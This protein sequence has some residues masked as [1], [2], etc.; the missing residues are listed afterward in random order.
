MMRYASSPNGRVRESHRCN[1]GYHADY[2]NGTPLAIWH[3]NRIF[4]KCKKNEGFL[5]NPNDL[6]E[7]LIFHESGVN[8]PSKETKVKLLSRNMG[9]F[10]RSGKDN[11]ITDSTR[12]LYLYRPLL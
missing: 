9:F 2:Y 11:L 6:L 5:D 3:R 7:V 4:C 8:K 10:T 12:D 1:S